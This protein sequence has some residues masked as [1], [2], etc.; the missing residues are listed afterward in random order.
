[1]RKRDYVL[2]D[3]QRK[4]VEENLPLVRFMV[5]KYYMGIPMEFEDKLSV[6]NIALCKA[7]ANFN[8]N[9]GCKFSTYAS[10]VIDWEMKRLYQFLC[11]Q[12]RVDDADTISL[13]EAVPT[14]EA[15]DLDEY[16]PD[17]RE[18]RICAVADPC[19]CT[20]GAAFANIGFEKLQGLAPINAEIVLQGKTM[21]DIA[22]RYGVSRQAVFLR[23]NN[24]AR[25]VKRQL[26]KEELRC[27]IRAAMS[28]A[29]APGF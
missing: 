27:R 14:P 21:A 17:I 25:K 22:R 6:G 26:E 16:E 11:R 8:P 24:E 29:I 18:E 28:Q 23:R 4:L 7:A 12:K 2:N 5:R 9:R 1:M 15:W 10:N 3:A 19:E 20:E 13:N